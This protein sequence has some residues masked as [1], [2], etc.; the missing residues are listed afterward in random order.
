MEIFMFNSNFEN[1]RHEIHIDRNRILGWFIHQDGERI[2]L[3]RST[4]RSEFKV[5][6]DNKGKYIKLDLGTGDRK[7]KHYINK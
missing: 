2:P 6:E 5:Y 7:I 4:K 1:R 3:K